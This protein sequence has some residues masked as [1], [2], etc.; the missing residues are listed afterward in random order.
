MCR[1]AASWSVSASPSFLRLRSNVKMSLR[2]AAS[3]N[4]EKKRGVTLRSEWESEQRRAGSVLYALPFIAPCHRSTRAPMICKPPSLSLDNYTLQRLSCT[5]FNCLQLLSTPSLRSSTRQQRA[6]L[7]GECFVAII[8]KRYAIRPLTRSITLLI[9]LISDVH[10]DTG[11][12]IGYSV[13]TV[14]RFGRRV[15]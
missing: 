10:Y 8:T 2:T 6:S 13:S 12:L 1:T 3:G 15:W 7:I 11:R 5:R 9:M 14:R 4:G